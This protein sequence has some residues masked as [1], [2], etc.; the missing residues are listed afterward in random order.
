MSNSAAIDDGESF[1]AISVAR[2]GGSVARSRLGSRRRV[3]RP[4]TMPGRT[5][6][7][8]DA[9]DPEQLDR[10]G[11]GRG[12]AGLDRI[13]GPQHRPTRDAG[14]LQTG[15]AFSTAAERSSVKTA[16]E[17]ITGITSPATRAAARKS[18]TCG[19]RHMIE[20]TDNGAGTLLGRR[21]VADA[22]A[23][24]GRWGSP[25]PRPADPGR[26]ECREPGAV[27]VEG[28]GDI[29]ATSNARPSPVTHSTVASRPGRALAVPARG[30]SGC[31][32]GRPRSPTG[33]PRRRDQA[34]EGAGREVRSVLMIT[35]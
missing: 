7:P 19:G 31:G 26:G 11:D 10:L 13:I 18:L 30:R 1:T 20:G 15:Q 32:P 25:R 6:H 23:R 16:T 3:A 29:G 4:A 34:R 24:A 27:Q 5:V 28:L 8:G 17:A 33:S 12:D 22:D 35:D 9:V 14:D 2:R 21:G